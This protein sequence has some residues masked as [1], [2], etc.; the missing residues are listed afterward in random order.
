L[1]I[2]GT[3]QDPTLSLYDSNGNVVGV[4]D[5]W[6]DA[7]LVEIT[8]AGLAPSDA[9]ESVLFQSLSPG[10]YTVIVAGKGGTAGLG[11]IEAYNVR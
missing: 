3:L 6:Q 5:N 7:S 4:N 9:R 11:L 2:A 1:G 10:A 8:K